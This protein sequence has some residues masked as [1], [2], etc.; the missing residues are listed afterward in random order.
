MKHAMRRAA[1]SAI[2]TVILVGA[3]ASLPDDLAHGVVNTWAPPS[4]AE[5]RVLLNEYG[6]PD[7]VTPGRITW[8]RRGP[9]KRTVVW[10]R[11]PIYLAPVDLAVM[12]QTVDY[13]LTFSQSA[14]LL[15]FSDNLEIDLQNGELS[16]RA[17]LESLNFLTLNLADDLVRG[18][19]TVPEAR[20]AFV[21]IRKLAEA[22]KSS[23][24]TSGLLFSPP[25]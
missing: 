17:G 16:S 4:A 21:R 9:W 18:R 10:N 12:K 8:N 25:G 5:A 3:C 15:A 20:E 7:D 2:C 13:P 14:D 1:Y 19:R 6:T 24:Y 23:P 22:G 11:K